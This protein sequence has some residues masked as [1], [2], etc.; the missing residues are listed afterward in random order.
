MQAG[1]SGSSPTKKHLVK[2]FSDNQTAQEM[3]R[4]PVNLRQALSNALL[5]GNEGQIKALT[6]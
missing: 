4:E 1:Q 2:T 3:I 5:E 6:A